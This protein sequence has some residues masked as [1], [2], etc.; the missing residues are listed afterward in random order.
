MRSVRFQG[1][2]ASSGHVENAWQIFIGYRNG[3]GTW[4]RL[5][6]KN[7]SRFVAVTEATVDGFHSNLNNPLT[8]DDLKR[9]DLPTLVVCGLKTR[10]PDFRVSEIVAATIPNCRYEIIPDAEHMSPLTHPQ[11]VAA[12]IE[13]I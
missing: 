11:V 2:A 13:S 1:Q 3:P 4:E 5:P 10:P 8:I 9:M 7:K 6:E 12:L